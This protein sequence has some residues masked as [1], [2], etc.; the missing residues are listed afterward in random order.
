MTD[1]ANE[2]AAFYIQPQ[3]AKG[4]FHDQL[5]LCGKNW[6]D[7]ADVWRTKRRGNKS[8]ERENGE[9]RQKWNLFKKSNTCLWL[10]MAHTHAY[11]NLGM[12]KQNKNSDWGTSMCTNK[13]K[14]KT[15][16]DTGRVRLKDQVNLQS[17]DRSFF[18]M[19]LDIFTLI[20]VDI[21]FSAFSRLTKTHT[22][23][24]TNSWELF[25]RKKQNKKQK[26]AQFIF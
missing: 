17:K 22:V 20:G 11:S 4:L 12:N 26:R 6:K 1:K 9:E 25:W 15:Y 21:A 5:K 3:K 18:C 16:W 24:N 2:D 19:L 23:S 10:T 8:N 7:P 13:K 14:Q